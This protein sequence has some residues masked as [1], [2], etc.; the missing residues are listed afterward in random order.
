MKMTDFFLSIDTLSAMF[1]MFSFY[2]GLFLSARYKSWALAVG[3]VAL[4]VGVVFACRG[5][6]QSL[7][8]KTETVMLETDNYAGLKFSH[9]VA[10]KIT[11]R[12]KDYCAVREQDAEVLLDEKVEE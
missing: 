1:A 4:C 5:Y 2:G 11:T 6:V 10:I 3:S 8:W 9:P 12:R 7:E